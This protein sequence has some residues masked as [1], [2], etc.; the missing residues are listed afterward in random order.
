MPVKGDMKAEAVFLQRKV[1]E[2][3]HGGARTMLEIA[4]VTGHT[5]NSMRYAMKQLMES[6]FVRRSSSKVNNRGNECYRYVCTDIPYTEPK[7]GGPVKIKPEE[8]PAHI[9]MRTCNDY[10]HTR[11]EP[12]R[13][14]VWIGTTLGTMTY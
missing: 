10:H 7:R 14:S 9:T 11:V 3:V 4:E 5:P 8:L 2:A 1:W 6:H 12:K 13:R